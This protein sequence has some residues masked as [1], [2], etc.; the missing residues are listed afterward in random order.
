MSAKAEAG[1]REI[2]SK[3]CIEQ[4]EEMD[5]RAIVNAEGLFI[6]EEYLTSHDGRLTHDNEA[7]IITINKNIREAG[8][9]N[10]TIAHELG[11][12]I[13]D[14]RQHS[15]C[16]R[17]EIMSARAGEETER[18]AN[19][20]AAELLMPE[21]WVKKEIKWKGEG[22]NVMQQMAE[23]FGVSLSAAGIRYTQAGRMPM[24]VIASKDD[25][26][27]WSSINR[28]FPF[29]FIKPGQ[30][31]NAYSDVFV[32]FRGEIITNEPHEIISDAWFQNDFNFVPEVRLMEQNLV[33]PNYGIVLTTLWEAESI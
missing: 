32:H 10:F 9:K 29:R 15:E 19:I 21:E 6:Q 18:D 26:V 25:K 27:I 12:F 1:A 17:S 5:L 14:R 24:A 4:S 31:T 20:F 28:Y 2:L 23:K 22:I 7:G 3:Y 16:N 33:M 8:Q 30:K 13:L 11:H